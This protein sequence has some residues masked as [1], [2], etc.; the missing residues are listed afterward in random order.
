MSGGRWREPDHQGL[1][2]SFG[3]YFEGIE[4]PVRVL[5]MKV[6]CV[7]LFFE[8]FG[9]ILKH[10]QIYGRL[11]GTIVQPYPDSPIVM[12]YYIYFLSSSHFL[13]LMSH[14]HEHIIIFYIYT[15]IFH[16]PFKNSDMIFRRTTS[17]YL[18]YLPKT[19]TQTHKTI[20]SS[21]IKFKNFI[22]I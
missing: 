10:F 7:I 9:F 14:T 19:R 21:V 17:K 6:M 22:L 11:A 16:E 4:E 20:Y 13:F 12:F 5:S 18:V 1:V 8:D 15:Y 3:L 2:W